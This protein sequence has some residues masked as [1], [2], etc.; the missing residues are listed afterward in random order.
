MQNFTTFLLRHTTTS[1][2][3]APLHHHARSCLS[4]FLTLPLK[5]PLR[6]LPRPINLQIKNIVPLIPAAHHI[7]EL[8]RL[9][10]RIQIQV[11]IRDP[12]LALHL[13]AHGCARGI[14]EEGGALG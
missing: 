3:T 1:Q 12:F 10:A 13:V 11:A 6:P 7:V 2:P 14:E 4:T 9:N 8:L 5:S